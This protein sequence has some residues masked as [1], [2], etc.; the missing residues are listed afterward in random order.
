MRKPRVLMFSPAFAPEFFSEA[1]VSSKLA[2][3]FLDAGWEVAVFTTAQGNGAG[4]VNDWSPPWL[5]LK[6]VR[7]APSPGRMTGRLR[8]VPSMLRNVMTV[9]H[10]VSGS[11]WAERVAR[12]AVILH[13]QQPFDLMLTRSTSCYAHLP[14]MLVKREV[15]IPWVANW[16]DPPGHLFPAPYHYPMPPLQRLFKDRYL[17]AAAQLAD[18]NSFPSRE[19][20]DYLQEP[21]GLGA[22]KNAVVIPHVG[23]GQHG[24]VA[25]SLPGRFRIIH[26]GNLS[27]ERDPSPFLRA[28]A[29]LVRENPQ[30]G[31]EFEIIGH[32]D[33]EFSP[34]IEQLGLGGVVIRTPGLPFL[35]CLRRMEQA[36]ALLLV[37]APCARGIFFPSKL[38]DYVEVGRPVLA[39]SP[40]GGVVERL[41][42]DYGFGEFASLDDAD[43]I[44]TGLNRLLVASR[45]QGACPYEF[46]GIRDRVAPGRIVADI[47]GAAGLE[48]DSGCAQAA[49][50]GRAGQDENAEAPHE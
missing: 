49:E 26:A 50:T 11:L 33:A 40:A 3:A 13:R 18:V 15:R 48:W 8:Q 12:E 37:E 28:L 32:M 34:L 29:E 14:A 20:L 36:D 23:L 41:V 22:A 25:G 27:R 2:L 43:A 39:L 45:R 24:S 5:P 44:R 19:L 31:I 16:N 47:A 35:E 46:A 38:I 4:Y 10:P 6:E 1:I 17:R 7:C 42:R 30:A 21:L 9:R